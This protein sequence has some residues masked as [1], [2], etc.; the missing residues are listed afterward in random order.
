MRGERG[1]ALVITLIITA[2]LVAVT[3]EFIHDVFVETSLLHGYEDAQQASLLAESGVQGGIKVLKLALSA[4]DYTSLLDGWAA[5]QVFQDERGSLRI[6]ISEESSKLDINSI[7]FPNGTLN[8][9]YY[10]IAQR[11]LDRL[12]LPTDLCDSVADWIDTDDSTRAGG[13]ESPFY[14]ALSTPY[15]AKNAPLETYEELRMV[16]GFNETILRKLNPYL[17]VYADSNGSIYSK[18]NINTAPVEL[19]AVLDEQM[20]DELAARIVGYRKQTPLKTPSEIIQV[21]G[22]ETIGMAVQGKI[23]VKGSVFRIQS[24]AQV[25]DTI[26]IIEAVV[27]VVGTDSTVLYWREL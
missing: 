9:D 27:R 3:T 11:L 10:G 22:M 26:R 12:G 16:S 14:Q 2:L 13:A 24:R 7:V 4:Q 15:F 23:S 21:P 17:T 6:S 8:E 18:M 19:L 25:R 1:F 20:T 5:P